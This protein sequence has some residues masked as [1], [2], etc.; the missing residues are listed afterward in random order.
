MCKVKVK[1]GLWKSNKVLLI[2]SFTLV[3]LILTS[4]NEKADLSKAPLNEFSFR[5]EGDITLKNIYREKITKRSNTIILDESDLKFELTYD[6]VFYGHDAAIN[7]DFVQYCRNFELTRYSQMSP[8]NDKFYMASFNGDIFDDL[9]YYY[10]KNI[11]ILENNG[12]MQFSSSRNVFEVGEGS[13]FYG[14]GL[15][16]NDDLVDLLFVDKKGVIVL[17]SGVNSGTKEGHR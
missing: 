6:S 4:C 3:I 15:F 10:E 2:I 5:V 17:Y 14:G 1:L 12:M 11:I 9:V 16:N 13:N 7:R 8:A